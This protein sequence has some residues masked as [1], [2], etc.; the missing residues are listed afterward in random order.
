[1][2][3]VFLVLLDAVNI[4]GMLLLALRDTAAMGTLLVVHLATVFTLYFA[5]P[6]SKFAHF[7]YRYAALVQDRLEARRGV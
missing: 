1:M 2:D 3:Y 6:Y 5:I 4:T 7:V